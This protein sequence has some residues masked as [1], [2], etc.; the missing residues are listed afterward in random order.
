MKNSCGGQDDRSAT[1]KSF[2]KL[3]DDRSA[4]HF[5]EEIIEDDRSATY[6]QKNFIEDE[7]SATSKIKFLFIQKN[8]T[9]WEKPKY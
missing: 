1:A 2:E 6:F 8:Y 7:R 9:I 3:L 5:S 4:R